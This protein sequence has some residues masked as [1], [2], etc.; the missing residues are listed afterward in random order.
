MGESFLALS[1]VCSKSHVLLRLVVGTSAVDNLPYASKIAWD[2]RKT[3]AVGTRVE[4]LRTIY[5]WG[6]DRTAGQVFIL[7]GVAG[8]GKTAISH[9]VAAWTHKISSG[10]PSVALFFD[11]DVSE[12][13]TIRIVASTIARNFAALPG[14]YER[15][16]EILELE[17]GLAIAGGQRLF[18]ELVVPSFQH[19][20][21]TLLPIVVIDGLDKPSLERLAPFL[22]SA[23][24]LLPTTLK[25]FFYHHRNSGRSLASTAAGIVRPHRASRYEGQVERPGRLHR[26]GCRLC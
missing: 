13:D 3:C 22:S 6:E 20:D 15:M 18:E 23:V 25:F 9:S 21:L 11:R 14:V 7:T 10:G 24:H 1:H 12:S 16:T 2:Q 4:I 5:D 19:L 17:P 8:A 26:G